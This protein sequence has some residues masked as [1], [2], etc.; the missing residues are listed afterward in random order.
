MKRMLSILICFSIFFTHIP[1]GLADEANPLPQTAAAYA[2]SDYARYAARMAVGGGH[3]AVVK[4][5][6]TVA[7]WGDNTNGQL[8]VPAGLT[9]VKVK[10]VAAGIYHTLALT[11]DGTVFAWGSV[12][13]DQFGTIGPI[14]IPAEVQAVQGKIKSI[15]AGGTMS[16]VITESGGVIAWGNNSNLAAIPAGL[17]NVVAMAIDSIYAV[18]LNDAGNVTVW[19]TDTNVPA[20]LAG[21]VV[22][23]AAGTNH[24]QAL[25]N[26]G[27]VAV[28]GTITKVSGITS[29]NNVRAIAGGWLFAAALLADGSVKGWGRV[30]TGWAMGGQELI[31]ASANVKAFSASVVPLP[32]LS[33]SNICALQRDGTLL[34]LGDDT[35][36]QT[37]I[38]PPGLNLLTLPSSNAGL[39]GLTVGSTVYSVYYDLAPAFDPATT[40]YTVNVPNNVTGV[41]IT[42]TTEDSKA[43]LKI[44]GTAATSG[45][46]RTVGSLSVGD[47]QVVVAVTAEDG[48]VKTYTLTVKRSAPAVE[49]EFNIGKVRL[50]N[51]SSNEEISTVAGQN[52]YRIQAQI[53]NN[54]AKTIDGLVIVQVRNGTGSSAEGGGKVLNCVGVSSGIS[55]TGSAVTSDYVLPSG[56]SGTAYVDV[57]VWNGWDAQVPLANPDH[58][59]SFTVSN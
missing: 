18:A 37:E 35:Y 28:S 23:I 2:A 34:A 44:N 39:S 42:A 36:Y 59:K 46:V 5:D 29:Q 10:A 8:N 55:A 17:G 43:S 53:D 54:G 51:P 12:N 58:N 6:G 11:E 26:D 56:L 52:G 22:A 20:G 48:T 49:N 38:T 14:T 41:D 27:T 24:W 45:M 19:G 57:F 3:M 30:P 4:P 16:A 21:N 40:A 9:G 15:A 13:T 1:A 47:N 32:S 31:S 50:L 7:V 33:A 25:K